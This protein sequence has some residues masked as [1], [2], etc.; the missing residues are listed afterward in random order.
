MATTTG[1]S[2]G[3]I[4]KNNVKSGTHTVTIK[5]LIS[6]TFNKTSFDIADKISFTIKS[7]GMTGAPLSI[8]L[9]EKDLNCSGYRV[10][11]MDT[12]ISSDSMTIDW[13]FPVD[14]VKKMRTYVRPKMPRYYVNVYKK[15]NEVSGIL[16]S[17]EIDITGKLR[18]SIENENGIAVKDQ[19]FTIKLS[20][21]ILIS[22]VTNQAG[23]FEKKNV[24]L[25]E[26]TISFISNPLISKGKPEVLESPI[27]GKTFILDM[28]DTNRFFSGNCIVKCL[29]QVD[30]RYRWVLDPPEFCIVESKKAGKAEPDKVSIYYNKDYKLT[31]NNTDITKARESIFNRY[32]QVCSH[33]VAGATL[34]VFDKRYW[35]WLNTE[36][37][38]EIKG[39]PKPLVLKAYP[40]NE[41]AL[42]ICFPTPSIFESGAKYGDKVVENFE[43]KKIKPLVPKIFKFQPKQP[44]QG[45]W[46]VLEHPLAIMSTDRPV[47]FSING[48]EIN[49]SF[50]D[51][52][53]S[54]LTIYK[55]V[56][57]I[58]DL[59]KQNIPEAGFY[60]KFDNK[61]FEGKLGLAW[62][63]KEYKDHRAFVGVA[64]SIEL[65]L[66][67]ITIEL[68]IGF[69][70]CNVAGQLYGSLAGD[71]KIAASLERI[72]PDNVIDLVIP[73]A[74][75]IGLTFGAR[76][77]AGTLIRA[78]ALVTSGLNFTAGKFK[79]NSS[80][81][82]GFEMNLK[83]T[84]IKAK[85]AVSAGVG[86]SGGNKLPTGQQA[87][88]FNS[89][90]EWVWADECDW[91]LIK[92]PSEE[93]YVPD[94]LPSNEISSIFETIFTKWRNVTVYDSIGIEYKRSDV[95]NRLVK[96][97]DNKKDMKRT[98]NVVEAI[99]RKVRED[100][101]NSYE[102]VNGSTG[103]QL[104]KFNKYLK[105]EF[106][107]LLQSNIDTSLQLMNKLK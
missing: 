107:K 87:E 79:C 17:N 28:F 68:G 43:D 52:I 97:I 15:N 18:I 89:G 58:V 29:H 27:K 9:M 45:K 33:S 42:S 10:D 25:G 77:K 19:K 6:V 104:A 106:V 72:S 31:C 35:K 74:A 61:F 91:G 67:S 23:I 12:T 30:N 101:K 48:Q 98:K 32:D 81:G 8:Q 60:Y 56:N 7:T 14:K 50:L 94:H 93:K 38:Y 64:A 24:L 54:I 36:V 70:I 53:G 22:G 57:S 44:D 96:E 73:F 71:I 75:N 16:K 76:V 4:K 100:F 105:S 63:W 21:G 83:W 62:S 34:P 82:L 99:A 88:A 66:V 69:D 85:V 41:Y 51:A 102:T 90:K 84:G 86:K 46:G 3:N 47:A 11:S 59:I 49:L 65:T 37:R 95:I 80:D 5:K 20:N 92:W 40:S 55:K 78:D 1:Q 26:H 103:L 13:Q 39:G 2:T